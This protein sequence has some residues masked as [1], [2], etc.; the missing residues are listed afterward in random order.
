MFL[1]VMGNGYI[2][3]NWESVTKRLDK[4]IVETLVND[5]EDR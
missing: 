5:N 1:Q 4:F 3:G 2:V